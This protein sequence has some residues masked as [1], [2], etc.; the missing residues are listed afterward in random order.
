MKE[1]VTKLLHAHP[2]RSFAIEVAPDLA[3]AIPA[4]DHATAGGKTLAILAD[5]GT[6][7]I[8]AY[9]HIR[10]LHLRDDEPVEA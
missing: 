6:F 5:D 1:Q 3:Y 8:V 2:F 4:P 9:R 10:R 7:D